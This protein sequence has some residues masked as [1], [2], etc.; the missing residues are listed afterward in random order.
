MWFFSFT[1]IEKILSD[2]ILNPWTLWKRTSW[3]NVRNSSE[4]DSES[5]IVIHLNFFQL[6]LL[7]FTDLDKSFGNSN[8]LVRLTTRFLS[9]KNKI[10]VLVFWSVPSKNTQVTMKTELNVPSEP[11]VQNSGP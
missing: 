6:A 5:F 1:G 2:Y 8:V 3:E 10:L 9:G 4:S 11:L 7:R